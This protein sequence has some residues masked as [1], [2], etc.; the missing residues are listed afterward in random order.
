MPGHCTPAVNM[1]LSI[2]KVLLML[3]LKCQE[4]HVKASFCNWGC[5][6]G[7]KLRGMCKK[8]KDWSSL[9]S[10][11][12]LDAVKSFV[13]ALNVSKHIKFG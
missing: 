13:T 10:T 5:C 4:S 6:C 7:P 9:K 11:H 1:G 3:P 2:Q 12:R 8:S